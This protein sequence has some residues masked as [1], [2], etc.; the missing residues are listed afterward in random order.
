VEN[1]D[2]ITR[3]ADNYIA[4]EETGLVYPRESVSGEGGAMEAPRR[5]ASVRY[6]VGGEV[7]L[8]TGSPDSGGQLVNIGRSGMLVRTNTQAAEGS[9][10]QIGF[11]VDGYPQPF[12]AEGRIVG[13]LQDLLAIR[14]AGEP[15][16]I[17]P[18][19]EWLSRENIPWTGLDSLDSDAALAS[20]NSRRHADAPEPA[21]DQELESILPFLEAMG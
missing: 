18:L 8:Y 19:L 16:E 14:F 4:Q 6:I 17:G 2:Q 11:A 10:F 9:T 13:S 20:P 12:R 3:I 7:T 21:T 1:G 15:A 5:R